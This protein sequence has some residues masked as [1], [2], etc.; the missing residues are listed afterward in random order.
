MIGGTLVLK[1]IHVNQHV[2]KSNKKHGKTDPA[3]TCKTSKANHKGDEVEIHGVSRIVSQPGHPL[4]CGA[5]VWVETTARVTVRC[6]GEVVA[7]L[8]DKALARLRGLS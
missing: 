3:L 2:V 4:P 1:R 8:P 7:D 5:T 6:G